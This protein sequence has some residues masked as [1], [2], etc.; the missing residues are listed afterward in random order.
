MKLQNEFRG[1]TYKDEIS[2]KSINP[3]YGTVSTKRPPIGEYTQFKKIEVS[4]Q[5]YISLIKYS[6]SGL[7]GKKNTKGV[8]LKGLLDDDD[9]ANLASGIDEIMGELDK[10][11]KYQGYSSK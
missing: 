4:S 10:Y 11:E 7:S 6:H 3:S 5:E 9:S 1:S 8:D 2:Y